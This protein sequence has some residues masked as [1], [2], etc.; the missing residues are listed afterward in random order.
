MSKED[1]M[2]AYVNK[3][4]VTSR[5]FDVASLSPE[6]RDVVQ[7]FFAEM[8]PSIAGAVGGGS[9]VK[10]DPKTPTALSGSSAAVPATE[11]PARRG[12][13]AK[14]EVAAVSRALS[15]EEEEEEIKA[16]EQER[17]EP[18]RNV[19]DRLDGSNASNAQKLL[20]LEKKLL[21]LVEKNLETNRPDSVSASKLH[22]DLELLVQTLKLRAQ[23]R[24]NA[25]ARAQQKWEAQLQRLESLQKTNQKRSSDEMWRR[26]LLVAL[27]ASAGT[28]VFLVILRNFF[29]RR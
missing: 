4:L 25:F 20:E 28:T 17:T 8:E 22:S 15:F 10:H 23:E 6:S 7:R 27:F 5:G 21:G 9:A 1:A 29:M 24:E 2:E 3:M 13:A 14:E 11:P 16:Q 12:G 19:Q 18:V 26:E